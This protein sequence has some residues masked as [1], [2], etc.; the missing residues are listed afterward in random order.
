MVS[1]EPFYSKINDLCTP[2]ALW[3]AV[4]ATWTIMTEGGLDIYF[5]SDFR[6]N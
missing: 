4:A 2:Q 1:I 6:N 5:G 3:E